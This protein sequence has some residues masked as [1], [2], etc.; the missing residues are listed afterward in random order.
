MAKRPKALPARPPVKGGGEEHSL[1][2]RSAESLGRVI[3]LLQRQLD[4][5]TRR[6]SSKPNGSGSNGSS[7]GAAK[8][9][10]RARKPT[11]KK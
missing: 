8:K 11:K 4:D 9:A 3:G 5:A 10:K 1:L 2:L 6:M 7:Q